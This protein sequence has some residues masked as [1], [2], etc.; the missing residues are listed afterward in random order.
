MKRTGDLGDGG[1]D[2]PGVDV[3]ATDYTPPFLKRDGKAPFRALVHVDLARHNGRYVG[4]AT[5]EMLD[6]A[7]FRNVGRGGSSI[8]TLCEDEPR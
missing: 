3:K 7:P 2:F 1:E 6:A 5:G 8:R 4:C